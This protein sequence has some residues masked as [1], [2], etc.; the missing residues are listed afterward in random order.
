MYVGEHFSTIHRLKGAH[1]RILLRSASSLSCVFNAYLNPILKYVP[2]PMGGCATTCGGHVKGPLFSKENM[3]IATSPEA[4]RTV[5]AQT[6]ASFT[7]DPFRRLL[8]EGL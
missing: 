8:L 1:F 2:T 6:V 3:G 5:R 7:C 4:Q